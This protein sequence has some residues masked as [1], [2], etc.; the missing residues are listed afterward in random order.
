M[1]LVGGSEHIFR[2][3]KELDIFQKS[4]CGYQKMTA[5]PQ[6][7]SFGPL[8]RLEEQHNFSMRLLSTVAFLFAPGS[9]AAARRP[10]NEPF[11]ALEKRCWGLGSACD[12]SAIPA[13]CCGYCTS[14]CVT[15]HYCS[16]SD[17]PRYV[18]FS[19]CL[20]DRPT[21]R[22]SSLPVNNHVNSWLLP[23]NLRGSDPPGH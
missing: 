11:H 2:R 3:K 5:T 21:W 13:Q 9:L 10:S 8:S 7:P 17:E 15:D 22:Y 19:R 16:G 1:Y 12:P 18:Q 6:N 14:T 20:I 23:A 4:L